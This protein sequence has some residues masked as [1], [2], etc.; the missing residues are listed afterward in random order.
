MTR[1][2]VSVILRFVARLVGAGV[3]GIVIINEV[4]FG[5]RNLVTAEVGLGEWLSLIRGLIMSVI[6]RLLWK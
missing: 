5:V 6:V 2:R 4:E 3:V 1:C